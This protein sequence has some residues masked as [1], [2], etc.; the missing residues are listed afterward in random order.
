M[1]LAV[2][3]SVSLTFTSGMK[4]AIGDA[5]ILLDG[6]LQDPPE[7][8]PKLIDLIKSSI[9][10]ATRGTA[11]HVVVSLTHQC[12]L[13]LQAKSLYLSLSWRAIFMEHNLSLRSF[14]R[15]EKRWAVKNATSEG[16]FQWS[17]IYL[18]LIL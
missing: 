12:P 2:L 1:L 6:D 10:L 5:V 4:Q 14:G 7:L 8:I 9:G 18:F 16:M 3:L 15:T 11:A 17:K 13:E